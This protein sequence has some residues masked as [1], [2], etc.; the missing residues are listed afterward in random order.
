MSRFHFPVK[1]QPQHV[2]DLN[3]PPNMSCTLLRKRNIAIKEM[4]LPILQPDGVLVKVI[5]TGEIPFMPCEPYSGSY[6]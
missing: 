1:E 3:L 2:L 4:P 5:A 6:S